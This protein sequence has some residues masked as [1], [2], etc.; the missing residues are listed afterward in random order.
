MPE[1]RDTARRRCVEYETRHGLPSVPPGMRGWWTLRVSAKGS[2]WWLDN[3]RVFR[4]AL[5][6]LRRGGVPQGFC[7]DRD[8]AS[9]I[10]AG[11]VSWSCFPDS[12]PWQP[13]AHLR[14]SPSAIGPF[15]DVVEWAAPARPSRVGWPGRRKR[16]K[17][18][19]PGTRR[20][21]RRVVV[22][23]CPLAGSARAS[24]GKQG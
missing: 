24:S 3:R 18:T 17:E 23:S 1:E 6:V 19:L 4:N 20:V 22:A 15:E 14:G 16:T 2:G 13:T 11:R 12:E 5:R 10:A 7:Y 21:R 8:S 9:D